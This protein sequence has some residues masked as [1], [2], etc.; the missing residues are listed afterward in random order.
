MPSTYDDPTGPPI[1]LELP[2][3]TNI[4]KSQHKG[5]AKKKKKYDDDH[6][7]ICSFIFY[8]AYP[9]TVQ[10]KFPIF[11]LCLVRESSKINY[12]HLI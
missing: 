7:S 1:L 10:V 9:L 5:V 8:G 11:L 3:L 6:P 12:G 4:L 2:N